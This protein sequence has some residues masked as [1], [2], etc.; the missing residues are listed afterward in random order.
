MFISLIVIQLPFFWC[1]LLPVL[2][3][4]GGDTSGY[5]VVPTNAVFPKVIPLAWQHVEKARENRHLGL[6]AGPSDGVGS[7]KIE[8]AEG[9]T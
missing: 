7:E 4:I 5:L 1:T 8:L 9:K 6:E 3:E 2:A